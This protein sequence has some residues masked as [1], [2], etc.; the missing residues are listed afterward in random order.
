MMDL[1]IKVTML[2]MIDLMI[3]K[4]ECDYD[5]DD[6]DDDGNTAYVLTNVLIII[7]EKDDVIALV[8]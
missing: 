6:D 5:D 4:I 3:M 8:F 1:L 7:K 2:L